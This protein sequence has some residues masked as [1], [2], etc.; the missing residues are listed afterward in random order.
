[1]H[2]KSWQT[3]HMTKFS[4]IGKGSEILYWDLGT[5]GSA[6]SPTL[7]K[8]WNI[9]PYV[10]IIQLTRYNSF[11]QQYNYLQHAEPV[12]ILETA[13]PVEHIQ[14]SVHSGLENEPPCCSEWV[15]S[16]RRQAS[17]FTFLL[18]RWARAQTSLLP[19]KSNNNKLRVVQ[20]KQNLRATWSNVKVEF[21]FCFQVLHFDSV[22][23][24]GKVN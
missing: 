23:F 21:K 9:P 7:W 18:A 13:N 16:F 17:D 1:M 4:R 20:G 15:D 22:S 10:G 8:L 11:I 14:W 3:L 2:V 6:I 12:V 24:L 5:T 19:T